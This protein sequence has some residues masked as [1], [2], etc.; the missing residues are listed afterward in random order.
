MYLFF[1]PLFIFLVNSNGL[2]PIDIGPGLYLEYR[3]QNVSLLIKT[4]L[5]SRYSRLPSLIMKIELIIGD[6]WEEH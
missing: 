5:P 6:T 3:G 4:T 1:I 2:A